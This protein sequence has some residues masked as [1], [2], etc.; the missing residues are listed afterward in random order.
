[1]TDGT[2]G[3]ADAGNPGTTATVVAPV[4][5]TST[6]MAAPA[7][8]AP[9]AHAGP[10]WMKGASE[11]SSGYAQNKGW[12]E[13][14]QVVESYINLEKLFGAD[15]AGR[16]VALPGDKADAAEI[17]A[18]YTKL[19]HPAE[20]KDYKVDIP[21]VGG[22]QRYADEAKAK[23][24]ELGLTAKQAEGLAA[25]NNNFAKT[26][27][28]AHTNQTSDAYQADLV[29]VKAEWGAAH[30]QNTVIARNAVSA[31]GWDAARIDKI[32]A[33]I[34]HKAT[35][36]MFYEIGSKTGEGSFVAGS[37]S[38]YGGAKTPAAAKA[39]IASLRTDKAWM[40]RFMNKGSDEQKQ[41][42]Q[43]HQY[44]FPE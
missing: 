5:T 11:L 21:A 30:D 44:A 35:M 27:T 26:A 14:T 3:S 32:S 43:L 25:W 33:A 36:Q 24:H 20:A 31:L 4:T 41:W 15:R 8:V 7:A 17:N 40:A 6:T 42:T 13:P 39:E 2:E 19:G 29:A 18:F 10:E 12:I 22:D 38:N 28:D 9:P 1:M 37:D 23:F 16:T 34:G